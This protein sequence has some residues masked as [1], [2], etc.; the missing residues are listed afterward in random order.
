MTETTFDDFGPSKVVQLY[1]AKEGVRAIVVIDN[2]ALGPA[3]GGVRVSPTVTMQEVCRLARTMTLKNSIAGLA[4]GGAK[5]GIVAHPDNP[6]KERVF[7]VFAR[8]MREL[9][10]YIPG[11]DMGCNETSMAWIH[12]ETGRSVGLPEELGGLP[13][14]KLGATGFGVAECAEVAASFADIKLSGARFVIEGFGS[15]GKAAARFL[16]AKGAVLVAASDSRGAVHDPSGINVD[17]LIEV[18]QQTGS[19]MNYGK[20]ASMPS[21]E[22]FGVPCEILIPAAAPDVIH[23]GNAG[24]IRTRL[25]LQ[26]ANIPATVQAEAQLHSRGILVVPDFIANAGGVIMA[27]MEYAGK[28]EQ[29][30]FAAI[31]ERIRKNTRLVLEKAASEQS[32]PRLAADTL[33]RER[34]TRAMSY[35][36]F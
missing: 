18:K 1:S 5:A 17:E 32:L 21:A 9:T 20:V 35:R 26:G 8:M 28:N 36:D 2:T 33:A 15:V 13:L 34:V 27:A 11:P 30:A 4:H 10:E 19:V 23:G 14:D 3:I 29:E 25:I 6:N 12:D 22:I 24:I 31:T 7:R 16:A